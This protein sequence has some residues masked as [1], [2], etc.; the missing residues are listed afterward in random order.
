MLNHKISSLRGLRPRDLLLAPVPLHRALLP[1]LGLRRLDGRDLDVV[2][3][4]PSSVAW[5]RTN[6][7]G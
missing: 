6:R 1:V 4:R 2:G 3:T 5:P 7:S